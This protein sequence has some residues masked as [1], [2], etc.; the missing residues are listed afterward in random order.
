[1]SINWPANG[2]YASTAYQISAL[3]YLSSS[4]I[5]LGQV[6]KYEF[7]YVTRFITWSIE[8]HCPRTRS[9]CR[10]LRGDY[11]QA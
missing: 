7:P 4:L 1:M 5:S 8:V 9:P 3:P 11:N 10:L 6:H 2:E